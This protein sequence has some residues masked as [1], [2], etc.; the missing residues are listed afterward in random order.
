[1]AENFQSIV[2]LGGMP[3]YTD[4]DSIAFEMTPDNYKK[5]AATLVREGKD[6]KFGYMECEGIYDEYLSVGPKNM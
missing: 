5:C 4:T 1:M 6:E 3:L 2:K